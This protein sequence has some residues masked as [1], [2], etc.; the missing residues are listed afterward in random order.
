MTQTLLHL[1][2][3]DLVL[4]LNIYDFN[5][6]ILTLWLV[7]FEAFQWANYCN[8]FLCSQWTNQ[9]F[10]QH[11][12][13]KIQAILFTFYSLYVIKTFPFPG[14]HYSLDVW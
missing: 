13:L 3:Y 10:G 5:A 12:Q 7:I 8:R 11:L 6:I 2:H 4:K 14:Y 9:C 1:N